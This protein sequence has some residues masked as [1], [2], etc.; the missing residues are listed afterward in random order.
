MVLDAV[1]DLQPRRAVR[2]STR[3]RGPLKRG[4]KIYGQPAAARKSRGVPI[5]VYSLDDAIVIA[6]TNTRYGQLSSKCVGRD[7]EADSM[8][9]LLSARVN[10]A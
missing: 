2:L 5:A 10:I 1:N 3:S 7:V 8:S 9:H 6:A 4:R